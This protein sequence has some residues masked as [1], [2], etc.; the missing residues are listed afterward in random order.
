MSR[1]AFGPQGPQ[2]FQTDR[3]EKMRSCN[4]KLSIF[5]LIKSI[6]LAV[7]SCNVAWVTQTGPTLGGLERLFDITLQE[8]E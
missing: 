6:S 2:P 3:S 1:N 5:Y 8:T 4:Q 7:Q